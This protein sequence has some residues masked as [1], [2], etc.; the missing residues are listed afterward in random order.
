MRKIHQFHESNIIGQLGEYVIKHW[1]QERNPGLEVVDK[2]SDK[3]YQQMDI[4]YLLVKDGDVGNAVK[5][6]IKTDT[7]TS[8]NIFFEVVS[9]KK[10]TGC[11]YKSK[12][13]FL[14]YFFAATGTAYIFAM[15]KL[16]N[17]LRSQESTEEFAGYR[18]EVVNACRGGVNTFTSIGYAIPLDRLPEKLYKRMTVCEMTTS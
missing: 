7:Y 17:W 10:S 2:R 13:D 12:A 16:A 14:L 8:G 5:L 11:I 9:S 3:R 15:D 1:L 18:K 4:D 6:E